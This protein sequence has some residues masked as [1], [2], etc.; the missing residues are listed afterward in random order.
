MANEFKIPGNYE[1]YSYQEA[2]K[3]DREIEKNILM[4][5]NKFKVGL[6]NILGMDRDAKELDQKL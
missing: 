4:V 1:G 2:K 3:V 6:G 5:Q